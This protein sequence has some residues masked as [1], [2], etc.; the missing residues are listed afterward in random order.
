MSGDKY[1]MF[2]SVVLMVVYLYIQS[3]FYKDE[4]SK[5]ERKSTDIWQTLTKDMQQY[6]LLFPNVYDLHRQPQHLKYILMNPYVQQII[7]DLYFVRIY[8]KATYIQMIIALEYFFRIH[9]NIMIGKYDVNMYLQTLLDVQKEV[10]NML[11]ALALNTAP[12]SLI[13]DIDNMDNFIQT[14]K[15]DLHGI[16]TKYIQMIRNKYKSHFPHIQDD[17]VRATDNHMP[18]Y[19]VYV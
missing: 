2:F 1:R 14:K 10:L 13:I 19:D 15:R 12:V 3:D 16:M 8:N 4:R 17:G 6:E 11:T 18:N 5:K 9:Y 7:E